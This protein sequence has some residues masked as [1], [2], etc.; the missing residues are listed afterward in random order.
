[1]AVIVFNF[2]SPSVKGT[3]ANEAWLNE[4]RS[5]GLNES[6]D[7]YLSWRSKDSR[8]GNIKSHLQIFEKVLSGR[9]DCFC[10]TP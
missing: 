9:V 1:M 10:V 4:G 2:W 5:A 8:I 7:H 6:G 3:L